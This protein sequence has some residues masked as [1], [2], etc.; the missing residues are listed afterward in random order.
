MQPSEGEELPCSD[1]SELRIRAR[2]DRKSQHVPETVEIS[3]NLLCERRKQLASPGGGCLIKI[4]ESVSIGLF[5]EGC[6]FEGL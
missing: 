4:L 2:G 1:D 3:P 6:C 5:S